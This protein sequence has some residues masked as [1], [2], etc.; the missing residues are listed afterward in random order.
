MTDTRCTPG[1]VSLKAALAIINSTANPASPLGTAHVTARRLAEIIERETNV[2]ALLAALEH[3][4]TLVD[5]AVSPDAPWAIAKARAALA[6][7]KAGTPT[8]AA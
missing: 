7:A 8:E 4:S 3:V 2:T 6:V 5:P 1:A